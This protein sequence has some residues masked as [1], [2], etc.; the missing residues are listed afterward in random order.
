[1]V[2]ASAGFSP[3][4]G[5]RRSPRTGRSSP[6]ANDGDRRSAGWGASRDPEGASLP[7]TKV[8][9]SICFGLLN[10]ASVERGGEGVPP[11]LRSS[12]Y[13]FYLL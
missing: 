1:M 2:L 3:I 12:D 7:G 6:R 8:I 11:D 9:F 5:D 10:G 4:G 13:F